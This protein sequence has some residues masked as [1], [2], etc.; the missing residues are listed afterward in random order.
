MK[1][2]ARINLR[3]KCG[4]R[5]RNRGIITN[6][7]LREVHVP[8]ASGP[9]I[10]CLIRMSVF[11]INLHPIIC[12]ILQKTWTYMCK[13]QVTGDSVVIL[14]QTPVSQPNS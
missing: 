13:Q 9:V 7:S 6:I 4:R 1:R 3:G 11:L 10:D 5:H 14:H 8:C 2:Q 12:A